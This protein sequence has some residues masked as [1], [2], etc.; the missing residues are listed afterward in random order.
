MEDRPLVNGDFADVS[1]EGHPVSGKGT[2]VKVNDV[3]IEIGSKDTVTE[4]SENLRGAAP[5]EERDFTIEYPADFPD[6]RLAG[7][8]LKYN[9]KV[10]T[11]KAK[12]LADLD[13][14]FA[15]ATGEFDTLAELRDDLG[16]A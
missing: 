8:H 10:H 16:P 7:R 13:D 4:F 14:D 11:I 12:K 5:G 6:K 9:V 3:L 15:K 2:P 1:F